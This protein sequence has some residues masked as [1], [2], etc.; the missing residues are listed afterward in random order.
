[1]SVFTAH[2]IE[3]FN[4]ELYAAAQNKG[5]VIKPRSR[6]KTGIVGYRTHFPKI[7]TASKAMPKTKHGRVPLLDVSR[8]RIYCDLQD[9]Y[10]A[11]LIDDLD[12]LKTNVNERAGV[13]DAI[14]WSL[15]RNE[16]DIGL[17]ALISGA[18][19]ND[20]GAS[21]DTWASDLIP[22]TVLQQFGDAEIMDGGQMYSLIKWKTWNDLLALV[23]FVNSQYGGD[24]ALTSEGQAPKMYFGFAY[25]PYSRVPTYPGQTSKANIW[26]NSRV[27]G[28]AVG[29]EIQM[30]TE[31]LPEYD[32]MQVMGKMSQGAILID[33]T[34]VIKRRYA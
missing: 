11:D 12:T 25:T 18:N 5:G 21:D 15:N 20:S 10:G 6:R 13:Q 23:S 3:V 31:R 9:Y 34:G 24:T 30:M 14:T 19:A 17:A 27:L 1:M 2:E 33:D 4:Q 29:A 28:V 7:G 8:T 26:W 22:R 16:D 32:A